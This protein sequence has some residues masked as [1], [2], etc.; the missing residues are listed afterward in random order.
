MNYICETLKTPVR[1]YYD[2][3][4]AGGG[5]GGVCAAV[6]AKRNGVKRVLI[7]EK[8]VMFGG[9][10]TL[11]LISWYEPICDGQGNKL[12]YGMADELLQ[13]AIRYGSDSLPEEWRDNRD[14]ANT[15]KRFATHF[16][17]SMF[18]LALDQFVKDNGV[19]ILFDTCAVIPH[20]DNKE[21]KGI[22]VENKT[23]RGYYEAKVVID[24]TGDADILS[25]AGVPCVNGQ[26]Y[27]TYISYL[28]N[29][30]TVKKAVESND[31]LQLR[32]W[33]KIGS[34]LWGKGHPEGSP[35]YT[36]VTAEEITRYVL[37]GRGLLL[38]KIKDED[39]RARDITALP[40]MGQLRTT[41]RIN[42]D[43]TLTEAD[44]GKHFVDSIAVAGDFNKPG[45]RYEIPYRTLLHSDYSNLLTVGRSISASG[46]AWDVTRV[47]PVAAAT[48]QGA[49]IAAA[50]CVENN[51]PLNK[52][53]I[54]ELQ[55]HLISAAVRIHL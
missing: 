43:Y 42:G 28:A 20:M 25:R 7:I 26:N 2:V 46:W 9:L 39:R 45:K 8:S 37:E 12:M 55:Q 49:G 47:I 36:G 10:A 13:L 27:L 52:V 34:N 19:D 30:E 38:N 48:G 5:V 29:N 33:L 15:S 21:C 53:E 18:T 54:S 1:G 32:T 3:I 31:I 4:V 16:S 6:S 51:I 22:I 11:G 44:E 17:H 35:M 24:A 40:Y 14:K 50:I 41:R 23:G